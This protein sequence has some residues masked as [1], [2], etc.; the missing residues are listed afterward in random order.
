MQMCEAFMKLCL[1][2]EHF[3]YKGTAV[4]TVI[5]YIGFHGNILEVDY[6]K[7]CLVYV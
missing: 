6:L 2:L 7:K 3:T 1:G 5:C 4:Y